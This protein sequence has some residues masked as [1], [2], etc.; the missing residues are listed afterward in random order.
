MHCFSREK[1]I[2]ICVTDMSKREGEQSVQFE[3]EG[4]SIQKR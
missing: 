3:I 4:P 2:I 1:G